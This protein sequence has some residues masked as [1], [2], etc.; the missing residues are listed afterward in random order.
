MTIFFL[1]ML[2]P[3]FAFYVCALVNFQRELALV[4]RAKLAGARTIPLDLRRVQ[5]IEPSSPQNSSGIPIEP[6]NARPLSHDWRK[7]RV[8]SVK[9][10]PPQELYQME[11]AYS[12]PL[13]VIPLR[14][15]DV[16]PDALAA[17]E[18]L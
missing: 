5:A 11:S 13:F 9:S 12:G 8:A 3:V 16:A 10:Q 15:E 14:D 18:R 4:K 7:A 17:H 2:V 6:D 1:T